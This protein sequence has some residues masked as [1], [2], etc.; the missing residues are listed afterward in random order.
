M[1][2]LNYKEKIFNLAF[3]EYFPPF[4]SYTWTSPEYYKMMKKTFGYLYDSIEYY[5]NGGH[6]MKYIEQNLDEGV[7]VCV[8]D[9]H[10]LEQTLALRAPLRVL[11]VQRLV[12]V[13]DACLGLRRAALRQ[14]AGR[15]LL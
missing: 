12:P 4:F 11:H 1:N 6:M 14:L 5:T 9:G 13:A 8:W 15:H 3:Q 7:H 10:Q 2:S